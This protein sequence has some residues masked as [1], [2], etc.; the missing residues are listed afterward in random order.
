M[1]YEEYLKKQEAANQQA[2]SE[3]S[4]KTN[5]AM[6]NA[7]GSAAVAYNDTKAIATSG[8]YSDMQSEYQPITAE[9][10][11]Q[12]QQ[13]VEQTMQK[14]EAKP[15]QEDKPQQPVEQPLPAQKIEKGHY[16]ADNDPA[17]N[18]PQESSQNP[19]VNNPNEDVVQG[20]DGKFYK[21]LPDGTL[22]PLTKVD[23]TEESEPEKE[24]E[25]TLDEG[26]DAA[27]VEQEPK[28]FDE[29]VSQYYQRMRKEEQEMQD[30]EKA[31][32]QSS[33]ATG[34]TELAAGIVN[35]LSVGELHASNQKYN[36]YSSD[37]MRKADEDLKEHRR[38][39]QNMRDTYE[40]LK[41]QQLDLQR[42]NDLEQYRQQQKREEERKREEEQT[43]REEENKRRRDAEMLAKGFRPNESGGYDFDPVLF[44]QLHPTTTKGSGTT[45][46]SSSATTKGGGTSTQTAKPKSGGI[47]LKDE[48]RSG[49]SAGQQKRNITVPTEEDWA[50]KK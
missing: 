23:N 33:M 13:P 10:I 38:R 4:A 14:P 47:S 32:V 18:I 19:F 29:L 11:Q 17:N 39:R 21:K 50:R 20:P 1:T 5:A 28:N 3:Q 49:N 42:A 41:R 46:K 25:E 45:S 34:A 8:G 9:S 15:V 37:W 27:E 24:P 43:R 40:R 44:A 6:A 2:L 48:L 12:P 31:N 35:M 22:A 16:D 26:G 36:D 30:Q 7:I